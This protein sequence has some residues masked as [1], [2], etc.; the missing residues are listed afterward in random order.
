MKIIYHFL[1]VFKKK[2][3]EKRDEIKA[4]DDMYIEVSPKDTCSSVSDG[5]CGISGSFRK[6]EVD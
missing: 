5:L 6:L 1:A 4:L 3:R 2:L